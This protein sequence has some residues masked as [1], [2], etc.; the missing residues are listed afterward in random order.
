MKKSEF[1][2]SEIMDALKG[3]ELAWRSRRF[4]GGD[5]GSTP[6]SD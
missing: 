4:A 6:A 1:T 2:D 5:A 3:G